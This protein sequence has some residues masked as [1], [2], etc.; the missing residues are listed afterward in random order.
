[1]FGALILAIMAMPRASDLCAKERRRGKAARE[2]KQSEAPAVKANEP[3]K[4]PGL[5]PNKVPDG[6]TAKT[7]EKLPVPDKSAEK[8]A[9]T[10]A[11]KPVEKVPDKPADKPAD[12]T[13]DK[14]ADKAA[15]K[16]PEKAVDNTKVARKVDD[17]SKPA[18]NVTQ[19]KPAIAPALEMARA[20]RDVLRKIPGYSCIF[21]KQEQLKK[22][23]PVRHTMALKLRREPFSVYLKYLDHA[24]GREVIYV[25]GRNSGKL[26]V[27]EGSGFTSLL[28]TINLLPTSSEAMKENKYPVT[29]I[30]MEKM[31][32][33]FIADWEASQKD[34]STKVL[35]YP[36]AKLGEI[37]CTM[38]EVAH[39]E[40]REPFKFHKSRVYFD[41]KSLLPIR[42]EQYAFPSKA[43]G[44]PQLVEEYT[45]SDVKLD[46][47]LAETDFDVKNE[48][49]GF[50]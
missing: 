31:L 26:Q 28:G 45:Y 43:G 16:S 25:E 8:P 19:P 23:S 14:V 33:P 17:Q 2:Q 1:M 5:D 21:S 36:Q 12:K 13:N 3:V 11:D 15:D 47:T 35:Y 50:K 42:A 18:V 40:K 20:S 24:A 6:A 44:E 7:I 34:A 4:L 10:T 37:D 9:E 38:Y 27:H 48:N 32:D 29:M 30:G 46:G 39:P 49:Y 22:G 41:K